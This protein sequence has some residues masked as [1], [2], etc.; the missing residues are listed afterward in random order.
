MLK[1]LCSNTE[2]AVLQ[3]KKLWENCNDYERFDFSCKELMP[4][5]VRKLQLGNE[6]SW[7]NSNG[8]N[9][10][11]LAGLP[12]F[13][14]TKNQYIINQYQ[15]ILQLLQQE[16]IECIAIK[17]IGEIAGNSTLA[18]AR[19]SRDIDLLIQEKDKEKCQQIIESMG[20]K[21]MPSANPFNFI[22]AP[23]QQHAVTYINDQRIID[24]DIHFTAIAGVSAKSEKFTAHLWN[25]KVRSATR[26]GWYIPSLEDRLIMAVANAYNLENW[27]TGQFSKYIADAI[28]IS[29]EMNAR[30][31]ETSIS[32][33]EKYLGMGQQMKQMIYV[34]KE[35]K[36]ET[37]AAPSEK[38]SLLPLRISVPA[39]FV[40]NQLMRVDYLRQL[41]THLFSGTHTIKT[42]AFIVIRSVNFLSVRIPRK[43]YSIFKPAQSSTQHDGA[44]NKSLKWYLFSRV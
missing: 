30:Q 33:G 34:I 1:L 25:R 3:W 31:I 9:S 21:I 6:P 41:I 43:I 20:W 16:G 4:S 32:D 26:P 24:L 19:T 14:W 44:D 39:A 35:I 18:M 8:K 10:D 40:L 42:I 7:K 37:Y 28:Q 29:S 5:A 15:S 27:K 23:L 22:S 11:F 36:E 2:E 38:K 17:G 13:T 12:R